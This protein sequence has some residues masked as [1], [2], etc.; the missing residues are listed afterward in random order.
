MMVTLPKMRIVYNYEI[1]RGNLSRTFRASTSIAFTT[2]WE[3]GKRNETFL[4]YP[5]QNSADSDKIIGQFLS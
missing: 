3:D 1:S 2:L 5:Q 4:S